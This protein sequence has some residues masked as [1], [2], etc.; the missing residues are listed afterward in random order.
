MFRKEAMTAWS[1]T[2]SL[3][4]SGQKTCNLISSTLVIQR[5]SGHG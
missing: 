5:E 1:V 2:F 4:I 3:T